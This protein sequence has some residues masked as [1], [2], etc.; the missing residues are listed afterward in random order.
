[1]FPYEPEHKVKFQICISVPL[2][3]NNP[4]NFQCEQQPMIL[5]SNSWWLKP[6]KTLSFFWY[7]NYQI[8]PAINFCMSHTWTLINYSHINCYRLWKMFPIYC[9]VWNFFEY[10]RGLNASE[11]D[12]T[13]LELLQVQ[14]WCLASL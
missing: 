7:S 6:N 9:R 13:D 14:K 12:W 8:H 11:G 10:I 4:Q 1:M 5:F 3:D 2:M